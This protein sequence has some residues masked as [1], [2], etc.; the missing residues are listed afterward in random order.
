MANTLL[1]N[2][3]VPDTVPNFLLFFGQL[4]LEDL[5]SP[6]RDGTLNP[7]QWKHRVLMSGLPGKSPRILFILVVVY[8]LS[9]IWFF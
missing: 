1:C 6:A 5:S 7:L 9:H 4:G 8:S 2:Y 3:Y